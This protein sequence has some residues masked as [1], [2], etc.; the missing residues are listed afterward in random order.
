MVMKSIVFCEQH[1]SVHQTI[2][3]YPDTRLTQMVTKTIANTAVLVSLNP[4]DAGFDSASLS[5]VCFG[6]WKNCVKSFLVRKI[7][8]IILADYFFVTENWFFEER[9]IFQ[10]IQF[11]LMSVTNLNSPSYKQNQSTIVVIETRLLTQLLVKQLC[12]VL[13]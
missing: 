8:F 11:T 13:K 9:N 3:V 5:V 4:F 10:R 7:T 12:S 6:N 1:W 2:L